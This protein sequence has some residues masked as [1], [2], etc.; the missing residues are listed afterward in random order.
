M[1]IEYTKKVELSWKNVFY[2]GYITRGITD[3]FLAARAAKYPFVAWNGF[4]YASYSEGTDA[5]R[6]VETERLAT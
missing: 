3:A 5:D 6:I 2:P 1:E 4:V